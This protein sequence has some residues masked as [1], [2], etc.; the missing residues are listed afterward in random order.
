MEQEQELRM[1]VLKVRSETVMPTAIWL[2][3]RRR[4]AMVDGDSYR[5]AWM[6]ELTMTLMQTSMVMKQRVRVRM[7][8]R[9]FTFRKILLSTKSTSTCLGSKRR[10]VD[11]VGLRQFFFLK[12]LMRNVYVLPL[13]SATV[14]TGE[15][16][17]AKI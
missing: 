8:R 9:K 4:V 12:V 6:R 7:Q 3:R 14:K 2:R 5:Q 15:G 13:K 16:Q 1:R 11:Q 10:R 17:R